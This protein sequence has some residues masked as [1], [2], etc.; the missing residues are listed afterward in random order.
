MPFSDDVSHGSDN[1]LKLKVEL[2]A[3]TDRHS[4]KLSCRHRV[5]GAHK[6]HNDILYNRCR[7]SNSRM[8]HGPLEASYLDQVFLGHQ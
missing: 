3:W 7:L 4:H 8:S 1:I 2:T 5:G 6:K